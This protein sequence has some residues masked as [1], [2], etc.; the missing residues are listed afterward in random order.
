MCL[1]VTVLLC[2]LF[3]LEQA[4]SEE[5]VRVQVTVFTDYLQR[6][7]LWRFLQ[8]LFFHCQNK[9]GHTNHLKEVFIMCINFSPSIYGNSRLET[10]W[11]L[12]LRLSSAYDNRLMGSEIL[13]QGQGNC[14][15]YHH[16][17]LIQGTANCL[18]SLMS[19][20]V[21]CVPG[22]PLYLCSISLLFGRSSVEEKGMV[23]GWTL[24]ALPFISSSLP[25]H[26]QKCWVWAHFSCSCYHPWGS[27]FNF[28]Y[29][30]EKVCANAECTDNCCRLFS[31]LVAV[32]EFCIAFEPLWGEYLRLKP[33]TIW[34]FQFVGNVDIL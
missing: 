20:H 5:S 26:H 10:N 12:A 17:Q 8:T 30:S 28:A 21:F 4:G 25:P 23:A 29:N 11:G 34:D 14:L 2:L 13:H 19:D 32:L 15:R 6:A 27:K 7:R 33:D 1:R 22:P 18:F 16:L 24:V 9:W 3:F 31:A